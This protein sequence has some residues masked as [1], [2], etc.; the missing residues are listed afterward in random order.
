MN[1][2]ERCGLSTTGLNRHLEE[3]HRISRDEY[4]EWA[5][6]RN[7]V[8]SLKYETRRYKGKLTVIEEIEPGGYL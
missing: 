2:C 3:T 7:P 1:Q 8:D 5:A 4:D 6:T